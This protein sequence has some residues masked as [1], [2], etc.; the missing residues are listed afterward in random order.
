[1][2]QTSQA[3]LPAVVGAPLDDREKSTRRK[4]EEGGKGVLRFGFIFHDLI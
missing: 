3:K 4:K 1:M 2:P